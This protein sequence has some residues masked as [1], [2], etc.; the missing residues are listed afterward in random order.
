MLEGSKNHPYCAPFIATFLDNLN[1]NLMKEGAKLFEGE[2]NFKSYCYKPNENGIFHRKISYCK[3][4]NN[5]T[6]KA[7]FFPKKSYELTVRG[8]G[9]MRNQIRLMMGVLVELGRGEVSLDYIKESL[10]T[11]NPQINY[12]APASGLM[13]NKVDFID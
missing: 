2:H 6:L 9:F 7:N 13:L 5:T 11:Y 10:N 12:I 1:I 3:I 8:K 4:S